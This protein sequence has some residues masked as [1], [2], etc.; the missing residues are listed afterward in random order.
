MKSILYFLF[1]LELPHC[2][3][4]LHPTKLR[5]NGALRAASQRG[6]MGLGM[7]GVDLEGMTSDLPPPLPPALRLDGAL[8]LVVGQTG[9]LSLSDSACW[10]S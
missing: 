10:S 6:Q 1:S 8:W 9:P 3:L 7:F 5:H 4:N 2:Y